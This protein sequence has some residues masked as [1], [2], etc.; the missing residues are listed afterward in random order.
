[1]SSWLQALLKFANRAALSSV[2]LAT[3]HLQHVIEMI[4][5]GRHCTE[6][7]QQLQAVERAITNAKPVLIH[8]HIDHCLQTD[9]KAT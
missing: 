5:A 7:A 2:G 3:D 1:M 6:I 9:E 4:E 8:D